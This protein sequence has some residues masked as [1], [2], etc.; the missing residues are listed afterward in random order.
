MHMELYVY[1]C[2]IYGIA[3]LYDNNGRFVTNQLYDAQ[4]QVTFNHLSEG[5]Y[6]LISMQQN[7]LYNNFR[8]E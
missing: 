1:V 7:N 6:T 8:K 4:K 5:E 2:G 3:M